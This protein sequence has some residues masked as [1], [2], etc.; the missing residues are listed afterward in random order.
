MYSY[1]QINN[2]NMVRK[3]TICDINIE[4]NAPVYHLEFLLSNTFVFSV[5][6]SDPEVD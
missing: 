2:M 1:L 3:T 5:V 4:N 6:V